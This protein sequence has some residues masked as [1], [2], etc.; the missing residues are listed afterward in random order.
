M[1]NVSI[2]PH[3]HF[4]NCSRLLSVSVR[5][6]DSLHYGWML[7]FWLQPERRGGLPIG[8][9]CPADN[10][11]HCVNK[12]ILEVV[13]WQTKTCVSLCCSP[14]I[15][16][17]FI[18]TSFLL[19]KMFKPSWCNWFKTSIHENDLSRTKLTFK[20]ANRM[21]LY[22]KNWFVLLNN[23]FTKRINSHV[24]QFDTNMPRLSSFASSFSNA[25]FFFVN[26]WPI[27]TRK[28]FVIS[29]GDGL[30]S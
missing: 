21:R 17:L 1:H 10:Q 24:I 6:Q 28:W 26:Q 11:L 22:I 3:F 8:N 27:I 9:V 5:L 2:I 20:L 15:N 19:L 7:E 4:K 13:Y 29:N 18:F 12:I 30:I 23:Q 16:F 14:P 25:S